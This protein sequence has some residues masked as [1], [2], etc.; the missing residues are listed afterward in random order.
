LKII[1]YKMALGNMPHWYL[2]TT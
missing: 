1:K 2:W